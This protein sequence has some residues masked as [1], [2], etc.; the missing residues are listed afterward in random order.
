MSKVTETEVRNEAVN[1]IK[2]LIDR[3]NLNPKVLKYFQDG[4]VYYSYLTAM[5]FIG[6]IDNITYDDSYVQAVKAFEGEHPGYFVYHIIET[7][8]ACGIL[9][10]ILY[11]SNDEEDW[12]SES[13]DD[14][15]I[16]SYVM[17]L[18]VPKF[19][20]FGYITIDGFGNSGALIRTDV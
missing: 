19:S 4:K 14:N 13:L 10:S 6:S 7:K 12:E 5:G 18:S 17:N 8:S 20:E 1:R 15:S 11:V 3:H 9:L 2:A 16:M